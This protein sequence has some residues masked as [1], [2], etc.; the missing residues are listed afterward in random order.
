MRV[1]RK[2]LVFHAL[3]VLEGAKRRTRSGRVSP[4]PELRLA[5]GV[6][7]NAGARQETIQNFWIEVTQEDAA[8]GDPRAFGRQQTLTCLMNSLA[9]QA[10]MPMEVPVLLAISDAIGAPDRP[11]RPHRMRG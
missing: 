5:L 9:N 6:L 11:R 1:G 2:R 8:E 4:Y 10:G 3:C 7:A